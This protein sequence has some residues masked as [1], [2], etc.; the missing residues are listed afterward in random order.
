MANFINASIYGANENTWNKP[1]GVNRVFDV[2][3]VNVYALT[4]PT[5]YSGVTCGT[6]IELLPTGLEVNGTKYY[7]DKTVADLLAQ[8][9]APLA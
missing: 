2:T 8:G 1:M 5:A 4:P 7:T 6:V 3:G 9:N